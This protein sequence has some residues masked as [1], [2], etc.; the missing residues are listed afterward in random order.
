[1]RGEIYVKDDAES[2][3]GQT[4][5][6]GNAGHTRANGVP[7]Q[8]LVNGDAS[9]TLVNEN[10]G[11][12]RVNGDAGHMRVNGIPGQT[13]SI[14]VPRRANGVNRL[15]HSQQAPP[16]QASPVVWD[17]RWEWEDMWAALKAMS[18]HYGSY[19]EIPEDIILDLPWI[20]FLLWSDAMKRRE[21]VY[22]R[23]E[24]IDAITK[25]GGHDQ[26]PNHAVAQMTSMARAIYRHMMAF[27]DDPTRFSFRRNMLETIFPPLTNPRD[28]FPRRF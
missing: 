21:E 5:V 10:T 23:M 28:R 16:R 19:H 13:R 18:R 6:N 15:D 17:P 3:S 11:H 24:V 9:H 22:A 26:I 25:Y 27:F 1:M 2:P 4:L 7:R 12:T 8:A 20:A 14:P